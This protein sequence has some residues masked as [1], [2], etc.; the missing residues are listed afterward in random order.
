[1]HYSIREFE[2]EGKF[3][4]ALSVD[5]LYQSVP[6]DAIADALQACARTTRRERKLN[7]VLTVCVI[8]ALHLFPRCAVQRVLLK[9][10]QGIRLLW[11]EGEYRLPG[12]SALSYR[13]DQVGVAP[14]AYLCR[15]LLRPLAT[16]ATPDAFAFGLRLLALDGTMD[17]VPDTPANERVFG[18]ATGRY[19]RS[20]FPLVRG[21][22]LV[23]CGTHAIL[24][25]TFWP[26]RVS[27]RRGSFRVLRALPADGLVM[28]DGGLHDFD[29]VTQVQRCGAHVLARLPA[30]VKPEGVRTLPDGTHLVYL[31]PT[32]YLRRKAGEKQLVRM[33]T[34][35][36]TDP[37]RS[38]AGKLW[39]LVTTLLDPQVYP[40]LDLV[41]VYQ[42]RWEFEV[43]LDEVETHQ[44]L[45]ESV[46]RGLTPPRVLQ[47][48]YGLVLAHYV[49]RALMH[50]AAVQ[51]GL[52]PTRLSF[53]QAV[54]LVR[55]AVVEFQWIAPRQHA[56]LK[57]RLLRDL[58]QHPL[59]VRRLRTAPR[60]VKRR[61][62][63]Y[64]RKRE[65]HAYSAQPQKPFRQCVELLI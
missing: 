12:A 43:T 9:L 2:T 5:A 4:Q 31:R 37:T 64:F 7:L 11:Q 17:A 34:C 14:M 54:E 33:I 52:A 24:D 29:L 38:G 23:E 25:C 47:E 8:I 39:R 53:V 21:V 10:A 32:A 44:R 63:K 1:M 49:I 30:G 59:P 55:Q 57:G 35:R 3:S 13:R 22:H 45:S 51:V 62:S 26:Y 19:E 58:A 42:R 50:E 28:W 15:H 56:A 18:R 27:E 60:V 16:P 48:L 41:E 40:A 46:L 65:W 61:L 6:K 36:L 20:A